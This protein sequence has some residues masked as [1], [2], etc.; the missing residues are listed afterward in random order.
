MDTEANGS[1]NGGNNQHAVKD[2]AL[3]VST[4]KRE[5]LVSDLG[6]DMLKE[7]EKIKSSVAGLKDKMA[8]EAATQ[9]GGGD[10]GYNILSASASVVE[11]VMK[12][13][14]MLMKM[15]R[16]NRQIFK[17]VDEAGKRA[18]MAKLNTEKKYKILQTLQYRR[19]ILLRE[20]RLSANFQTEQVSKIELIDEDTF[21][22][23]GPKD[24]LNVPSDAS[25]E[26]ED[27]IVDGDKEHKL[28]LNRL[29]HELLMRKELLEEVNKIKKETSVTT[30]SISSKNQFIKNLKGSFLTFAEA[31]QPFKFEQSSDKPSE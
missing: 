26:A 10:A 2:S 1:A 31:A 27:Q 7:I 24:L 4:S 16:L 3:S 30:K 20:V 5:P 18:E 19:A 12:Q 17:N 8:A 22:S 13:K 25:L 6:R 21:R 14:Q 28:F 23:T 15:K 29:S 11:D 9:P